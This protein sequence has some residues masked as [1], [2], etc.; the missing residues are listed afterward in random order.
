MLT[1]LS[2]K[3]PQES[4]PSASCGHR[5][6]EVAKALLAASLSSTA[7]S[8][9]PCSLKIS[10]CGSIQR[11]HQ[12]QQ[13]SFLTRRYRLFTALLLDGSDSLSLQLM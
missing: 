6:R 10:A 4:Q 12:H 13:C 7:A 2:Q 5:A 1:C 11:A 9:W 3:V 8:S